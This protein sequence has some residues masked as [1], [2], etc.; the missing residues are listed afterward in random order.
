MDGCEHPANLAPSNQGHSI[1][2]WEGDTLVVDT[3]GLEEH[4]WGNGRGI[5]SSTQR[6]SVERLT[7][8]EDGRNVQVEYIV[9]DPE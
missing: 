1:G 5:P 7:L 3:I 6:H 2:W 4:P 8:S 9:D